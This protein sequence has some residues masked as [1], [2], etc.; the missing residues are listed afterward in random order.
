M[1]DIRKPTREDLTSGKARH[2]DFRIVDVSDERAVHDAFAAPWPGVGESKEPEITVLHT[3]ANIRFYER[4]AYLLPLS[5]KVNVEGTRNVISAS[6][7]NGVTSLIYTSSGSILIRRAR[8]WLWPWETRPTHFIQEISDDLP[9]SAYHADFF[10]NYAYTKSLG[11]I[12]VR[13]ADKTRNA[14]GTLLRTGCLRPGNG[15]FG[16]GDCLCGATLVRRINPTWNQNIIQNFLYVENCS[17]AHLC[18]EARLNEIAAHADLKSNTALTPIDIGGD[19][20]VI[21]DPNPPPTYGDVYK[22]INLLSS[23]YATFPYLSPTFMLTLSH[24]FENIYLIR[25]RL[26]SYHNLPIPHPLRLL[27]YLAILIPKLNGDLVSLQPSMF[28]LIMAH[29]FFD[30][31]R[32]R[33]PPEQGGL[34]YNSP[35]TT[36]EGLCKLV[37][38]FRKSNGLPDTELGLQEIE[39]GDELEKSTSG[40]GLAKAQRGVAVVA[41][42]AD[43]LHCLPEKMPN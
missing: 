3:A 33:L 22:A 38:E 30:D 37:E 20:F 5:A 21:A 39:A 28:E 24:I 32:A 18:Y 16:L 31:S 23:S 8:L 42:V 26:S 12:L 6:L 1:L 13:N 4:V 19:A 43:E 7:A 41:E 34:G 2:V 35:W 17:I 25:H 15:I 14:K 36:L 11:E 9:V 27:S 29:L 10:S 40:F